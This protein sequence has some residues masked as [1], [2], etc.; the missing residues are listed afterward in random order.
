MFIATAAS[1]KVQVFSADGKELAN[2]SYTA[3][4]AWNILSSEHK[5]YGVMLKL[6]DAAIYDQISEVEGGEISK[7]KSG[8]PALILGANKSLIKDTAG[9]ILYTVQWTPDRKGIFVDR[10]KTNIFGLRLGTK[11]QNPEFPIGVSCNLE[12]NPPRFTVSVPYEV[13]WVDYTLTEVAGKGERWREFDVPSGNLKDENV[14]SFTFRYQDKLYTLPVIVK[15]LSEEIQ[16]AQGASQKVQFDKTS[17]IGMMSSSYSGTTSA[18]ASSFVLKFSGLTENIFSKVRYGAGFKGSFVTGDDSKSIS[19]MDLGFK[20]GYYADL[21]NDYVL[22][23]YLQYRQFN[24]RHV[25]SEAQVQST[26]FGF[27]FESFYQ[28]APKHKLYFDLNL[29]T[30]G[31]KVLKSHTQISLAYKY[32]V[33]ILGKEAWIGPFFET[34]SVSATSTDGTSRFTE[35]SMMFASEY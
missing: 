6:N 10:C 30:L 19:V 15:I 1:A 32:Q 18:S 2:S 21:S 25:E 28:I 31:S 5:V 13:E 8:N 14:G 17:G 11:A 22:G 20:L 4:E 12:E 3:S 26:Q 29:A 23:S 9:N 16:K 34:Q 27:G 33:M 7:D 35:T 24:F